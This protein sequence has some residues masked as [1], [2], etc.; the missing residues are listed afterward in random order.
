VGAATI[1]RE[2]VN[3]FD[4][5]GGHSIAGPPWTALTW[6]IRRYTWR[7]ICDMNW[8]Y[9]LGGWANVVVTSL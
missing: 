4:W 2:R 1:T 6:N 8:L 5:A 9:N 3:E 7:R